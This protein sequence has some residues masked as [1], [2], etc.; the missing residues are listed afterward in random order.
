M[1]TNRHFA[2]LFRASIGFEPLFDR[3]RQAQRLGSD[4]SDSWP[5]CDIV[6]SGDTSYRITLAVAGFTPDALS[7]IHEPN[8]LVVTGTRPEDD[9]SRYLHHGI[10]GRSFQRRFELA[11]HVE[12]TGA[13][14]ENGLLTIELTREIPEAMRPRRIAIGTSAGPEAAPRRIAADKRAA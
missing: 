13:R 12:V 3:L 6:R 9:A 11:D 1:R 2:P 5:P 14:L 10:A 8:L 7:I 4:A